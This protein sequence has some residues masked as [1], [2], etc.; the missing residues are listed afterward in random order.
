MNKLFVFLLIVGIGFQSV[1]K[2]LVLAWYQVNKTYIAQKLCENRNKP[3]MHC[4]G[5]CQL[6]KKMQ[7]LDQESPSNSSVP[8]K[9]DKIAILEFLLPEN[10]ASLNNP[11]SILKKPIIFYDKQYT[12]SYSN[13]L[14]K[15]PRAL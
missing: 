15:P 9:I 8:V 2:L 1:G 6:R 11:F 10:Q 3:K 12:F 13:Y 5:K 4:N 7:Q 14:L